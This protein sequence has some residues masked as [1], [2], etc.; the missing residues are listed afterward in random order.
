VALRALEGFAT[1]VLAVRLELDDVVA[2]PGVAVPS[3]RF[4][5]ALERA[6]GRSL[7]GA[8]VLGELEH[9]LERPFEVA[10]AMELKARTFALVRELCSPRERIAADLS[11]PVAWHWLAGDDWIIEA[12]V[13]G[14]GEGAVR[15]RRMPAVETNDPYHLHRLAEAFELPARASL[16]T[17]RDSGGVSWR[18]ADPVV[19]AV[20][21]VSRAMREFNGTQQPLALPLAADHVRRALLAARRR[22]L[23]DARALAAAVPVLGD[24]AECPPAETLYLTLSR[25][26]GVGR[27]VYGEYLSATW[28]TVPS[29]DARE[30]VH[31]ALVDGAEL[32]SELGRRE[33][34]PWYADALAHA[35]FDGD[36]PEAGAVHSGDAS[37]LVA[38]LVGYYRED[39]RLVPSDSG[40]AT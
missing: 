7:G 3:E 6:A 14:E 29:A 35:G 11:E 19:D 2:H 31:V 8:G 20:G 1:E 38:R 39:V 4:V 33:P 9:L 32:D 10:E 26:N 40:G 22:S 5:V 28:A 13:R 30:D 17:V 34:L 21:L 24:R 23:A 16:G 12:A 27:L 36:L 18:R 25:T 37:A 15:H